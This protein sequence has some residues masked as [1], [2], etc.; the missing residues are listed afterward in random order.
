MPLAKEDSHQYVACRLVRT[1]RRPPGRSPRPAEF[2]AHGGVVRGSAP[3]SDGWIKLLNGRYVP[4]DN[5][6]QLISVTQPLTPIAFHTLVELP[7]DAT[8]EDTS[9][10]VCEGGWLLCVPRKHDDRAKRETYVS[11]SKTH[12]IDARSDSDLASDTNIAGE[13]LESPSETSDS[14]ADRGLMVNCLRDMVEPALQE[15]S[16]TVLVSP[17]KVLCKGDARIGSAQGKAC[18]PF[19]DKSH[20][21]PDCLIEAL[22]CVALSTTAKASDCGS[23][24]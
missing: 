4:N 7:R 18:T 9:S 1:F 23:V 5:N 8:V 21:M 22:N 15:E 3:Q 24:C 17:K 6:I 20:E 14:D 19:S 11:E 12:G 16:E 13:S 2:L 10:H